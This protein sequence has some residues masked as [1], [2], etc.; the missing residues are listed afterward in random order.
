MDEKEILQKQINEIKNVLVWV[1]IVSVTTIISIG[2]VLLS[3]LIDCLE[4][5]L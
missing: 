1:V 5:S 4:K 2:G 3:Q